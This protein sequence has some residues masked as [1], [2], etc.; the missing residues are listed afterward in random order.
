MGSE[1]ARVSS[2][3]SPQFNPESR[4]SNGSVD[5]SRGGEARVSSSELDSGE[6]ERESEGRVSEIKD[7]DASDSDGGNSDFAAGM[8]GVAG[9]HA[10][11]DSELDSRGGFERGAGAR[12][13]EMKTEDMRFAGRNGAECLAM[14][15]GGIE[16]GV[17]AKFSE[18]DGRFEVLDAGEG[19]SYGFEAGDMVWGK[20]KSHPWWPGHI[21]NEAFAS[22]SVRRSKREGH[23]LVAFF[24]DSSYG[25]FDPAE[26]IPFEPH[27]GE[28]SRQT[29]S[30]NFMKAVEEAVDEGKRR[31]ALGLAC[32]CRNPFNFRPAGVEGYF[33]VD[34]EEYDPGVVYSAKQIKKARDNFQPAEALS[35]VQRLALTPRDREEH[36]SIDWIHSVATVLAYRK[37]VFEEFDETYAQAFGMQPVRPTRNS[38]EA[39]EQLDKAL[40]RAPLSGP[41]VIAENLGERKTIKSLKPKKDKYLFKRREEPNDQR[42]VSKPG[43]H[44]VSQVQPGVLH[45]SALKEAPDAFPAQAGQY[46][47]Q[48]RA[49]SAV[50]KHLILTSQPPEYG[51]VPPAQG[52]EDRELQLGSVDNKKDVLQEMSGS[53]RSD[54]TIGSTSKISDTSNL[55]GKLESSGMVD[56]VDE[57]DSVLETRISESTGVD[58]VV[59]TGKVLKRLWEDSGSEKSV[60]VEKNKKKK[61]KKDSGIETSPDHPPK[62]PKIPKDGE[63]KRKSA[64]KSPGISLVEHP[65][66]ESQK[67][68]DGVG[69]VL[70]SSPAVSPPKFDIGSTEIELPELVSDLLVLALDPFHGIERNSPEIVRQVF[71][72]FRSLVYQKS[73][74]LQQASESE[75]SEVRAKSSVGRLLQESGIGNAEI[76]PGGERRDPT[77]ASKSLKHAPRLDDPTKMGRKRSPSDRQEEMSAK[78]LKKLNEMK[79]LAA[80]KK[81]G[82]QKAA[83]GQKGEQKE[84][85]TAAPT[86]PIKPADSVKK[87]EP[88]ARALALTALVMKFP[89]RTTLP[90]QPQLKARFA[91]F[92]PLDL[93]GTRVYWKSLTC[94]VVFRH[95]ADAEAAYDHAIRNNTL[96]GHIRVRYHLRELETPAPEIPEAGKRRIDDSPDDSLQLRSGCSDVL[97]EPKP[98]VHRQ[99]QPTVQLKS[100]LKKPSGDE[101]GPAVKES[102]RVK[103]LLGGEES[104]RGEQLVTV[105]NNNGSNADGASSSSQPFDVTSIKNTK[106]TVFLPP[107]PPLPPLPPPPPLPPRVLDVHESPG[108]GHFSKIH[109]NRYGHVPP[110]SEVE[111][112]N[113]S[114]VDISHQML[115]LL[116]RCSDI[117]TDVNRVLGY[118]PYHPL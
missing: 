100:C 113:T 82:G 2:S 110:Y 69:A 81:A 12:V 24:G 78:R 90:S 67:R 1:E 80:E 64:G 3:S 117:V 106:S 116:M 83:D 8:S 96:F 23:V 4:V 76:A 62:R 36:L 103:F 38:L 59:K 114:V 72:K 48:R 32:R 26:L 33:S 20:V 37:A 21:F 35:F 17:N 94:R 63:S 49:L 65:Q 112:R 57:K 47:L 9:I 111:G 108:V 11:S 79:A 56:H 45:P 31:R 66:M 58:G 71:L 93:S 68:D 28:K 86:K 51:S 5:S 99:L 40:P 118:V 16:R 55:S 52:S 92:G 60:M 91:R 10:S 115:S 88:P 109:P 34:V 107:P 104:R 70:S 15:S 77:S 13:S 74:V 98:M 44:H 29:N 46:V 39:L 84:T 18:N 87:P 61:K 75:T 73:L 6:A 42:A 7:E 19:L 14:R 97:G 43:S 85:G 25:W 22:S 41:L 50:E 54:E 101:V 53:A 105:S 95:K 30:R 89:P 102:P 27:Y